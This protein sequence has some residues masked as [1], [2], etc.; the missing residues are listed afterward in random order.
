[1][2]LTILDP[3]QALPLQRLFPLELI[4]VGSWMEGARKTEWRRFEKGKHYQTEIKYHEH[5][6]PAMYDFMVDLEGDVDLKGDNVSWKYP[7]YAPFGDAFVP[8]KPP[9]ISIKN[10]DKDSTSERDGEAK[11]EISYDGKIPSSGLV[12]NY[13]VEI[14]N[15]NKKRKTEN[16]FE[17]SKSGTI[18]IENKKNDLDIKIIDD[19][20]FR[21]NSDNY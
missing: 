11:F 20:H 8:D 14:E 5:R 13:K 4:H 19:E 15:N 6:G 7:E 10:K 21:G 18:T 2:Q 3:D 16:D 17:D 12:V 1:M 9:K